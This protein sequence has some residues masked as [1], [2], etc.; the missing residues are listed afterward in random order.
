LAT[1][2][3]LA[4]GITP[5]RVIFNVEGSGPSVALAD[6]IL[7]NGTILAPRQGLIAGNGNTP[8][9]M[10]IN[11]ALL[12]GGDI[13]IGN[14]VDV[15]FYPLAQVARQVSIGVVGTVNI[16]D[17]PP[18]VAGGGN[19]EADDFEPG[20]HI[21]EVPGKPSPPAF[22]SALSLTDPPP[23]VVLMQ[24]IGFLGLGNTNSKVPPDTQ[25]AAGNTRLVEMVNVSGAEYGKLSGNQI[26]TFDLGSLFLTN[27][28]Q[29]TD[30]RV[31]FDGDTH[32]YFAAYELKTAGG[33]DI[34]LAVADEPGDNWTIYEV[35]G[36]NVTGKGIIAFFDGF[37]RPVITAR[38]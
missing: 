7:F 33:D 22:G 34:R 1:S 28:G 8:Q 13:S 2:I 12:F 5:E 6:N 32:T 15:N 21:E 37:C 31:L 19:N 18:P 36:N 16:N 23:D 3:V 17:L 35:R 4:G 26:K 30:P 25:L 9:P 14:N 11:G 20:P 38:F 10:V 27:K 29:G 24:P